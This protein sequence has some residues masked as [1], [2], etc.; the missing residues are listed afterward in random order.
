MAILKKLL[1]STGVVILL[2]AGTGIY[3]TY[4]TFHSFEEQKKQKR[5]KLVPGIAKGEGLFKKRLF[6]ASDDLGHVSEIRIGWPA[7]REA[8]EIAVVGTVGAHFLDASGSVKKEV[9]FSRDFL[10]ALEVMQTDA[11]GEYAYLSRDQSWASDVVLFDKFGQEKWSYSGPVLTGIDDSAS[12]DLGGEGKPDV[13]V[14]LNGGGGIVLLDKDGKR[15]WRKPEGNVWHVEM[16]DTAGDGRKRI[17]H[18]NAEGQ[19][20][21]RNAAGDVIAKYLSGTY[22]SHFSL[23]RWNGESQPTHILISTTEDG[24]ESW[25]SIFLILNAG[26][27]VIA[28]MQAPLGNVLRDLKGT[29]VRFPGQGDQFAVL[30]HDGLG[31]RSMLFVYTP[32]NQLVYQ[33]IIGDSCGAIANEAGKAGDRLLLGCSGKVWEYALAAPASSSKR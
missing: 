26:G 3:F 2:L 4:R 30:E 20:L 17:L 21:V 1:I 32:Q 27:Q 33:E 9:R 29:S 31:D 14:G 18:S 13:V 24:P 5:D 28:R 7:T 22:V 11:S 23:V 10:F 6:Y 16:L 19:L 12:G 8:A 25:D 15:L